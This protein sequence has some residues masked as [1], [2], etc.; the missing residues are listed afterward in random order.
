MWKLVRRNRRKPRSKVLG[1]LF[2]ALLMRSVSISEEDL[3]L[4]GFIYL[5]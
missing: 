3:C 1:F 5:D 4:T 2:I